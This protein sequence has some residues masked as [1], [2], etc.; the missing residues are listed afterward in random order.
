MTILFKVGIVTPDGG[1]LTHRVVDRR[2]SDLGRFVDGGRVIRVFS[3]TVIA[4]VGKGLVSPYIVE[5]A[6]G[7]IDGGR[8]LEEGHVGNR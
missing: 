6:M 7:R 8:S 2:I 4:V 1:D 3:C 5:C